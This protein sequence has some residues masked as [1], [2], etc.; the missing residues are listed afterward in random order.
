MINLGQNFKHLEDIESKL[1]ILIDNH[2]QIQR[3]KTRKNIFENNSCYLPPYEYLM[4]MYGFTDDEIT[5]MQIQVKENREQR[6]IKKAKEKQDNERE[7]RQR[8]LEY[9]LTE[10][11][12]VINGEEIKIDAFITLCKN[13]NIDIHSSSERGFRNNVSRLRIDFDRGKLGYFTK[14]IR[15]RVNTD[16]L[17]DLVKQ[18]TDKIKE[19][20]QNIS[21]NKEINN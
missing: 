17:D 20:L 13:Y 10:K 4:A 1:S 19:D 21:Q 15:S 3:D 14:S 8:M 7:T 11:D 16:L 18:L 12:N 5:D 6:E 9:V 2:I